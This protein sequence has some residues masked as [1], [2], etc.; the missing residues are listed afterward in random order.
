LPFGIADCKAIYDTIKKAHPEAIVD[1]AHSY[2]DVY[3]RVWLDGAKLDRTLPI[4]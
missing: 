1:V 3:V 2:R 4:V